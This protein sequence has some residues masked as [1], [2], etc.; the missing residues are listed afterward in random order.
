MSLRSTLS[1]FVRRCSGGRHYQL[2]LDGVIQHLYNLE[3]EDTTVVKDLKLRINE[4]ENESRDARQHRLLSHPYEAFTIPEIYFQERTRFLEDVQAHHPLFYP[5]LLVLELEA[6]AARSSQFLSRVE[7]RYVGLT[8]S[9][10]QLELALTTELEWCSGMQ[11]LLDARS[12]SENLHRADIVL[13][14]PQQTRWS[15]VDNCEML[16][17]GCDAQTQAAGQAEKG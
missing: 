14:L 15:V 5:N 4:L 11:S 16:R 8:S 10:A 3:R 9:P 7:C 13:F 2:Q 6:G 12:I 1:S 17:G